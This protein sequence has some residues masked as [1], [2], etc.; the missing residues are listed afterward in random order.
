MYKFHLF[1]VYVLFN[2]KNHATISS[3]NYNNLNH[4]IYSNFPFSLKQNTNI[5]KDEQCITYALGYHKLRLC[6]KSF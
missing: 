1:D 3:S 4:A 5:S 2:P 6:P